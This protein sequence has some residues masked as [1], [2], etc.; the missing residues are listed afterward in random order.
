MR[1]HRYW[2]LVA[3]VLAAFGVCNSSAQTCNENLLDLQ[4]TLTTTSDSK[5]VLRAAA[6]GGSNFIPILHTLSK[7]S[8]S[9]STVPG[10]AQVA[11][12]RLG[13]QDAFNQLRTEIEKNPDKAIA[14]LTIIRT[15]ASL[16]ILM[17]YLIEHKNDPKRIEDMGDVANDPLWPAIQ[18]MI[19]MLEDPPYS[20]ASTL[21]SQ[22]DGW[23][24][25]WEQTKP[26]HITPI[27]QGLADPTSVCL[28]RLSEWG[29]ADAVY[30]LY[31][32]MGKNSIPV[33]KRLA[34]LG[35][36]AFPTSSVKTVR[37]AAQTLLAREGDQEQ[38]E[39]IVKELDTTNYLD[40][41]GKLQYIG[42]PASFEALM[43]SLTLQ[44]FLPNVARDTN[45]SYLDTESK[46]LREAV[47][48]ALSNLV[49]KPPLPPQAPPTS[50]NIEK[51]NAWWAANKGK[52]VFKNGPS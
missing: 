20:R 3:L 42:G 23:Q 35:D 25:W 41:V 7:P 10:A 38:F 18:G 39:K 50:E 2:V 13:D 43:H 22:L 45:R 34:H 21:P 5:F 28:A 1:R 4:K 51:W 6:V 48:T 27:S 33:L 19:N 11:L 12:A 29:Y 49:A 26:P 44:T 32:H 8:Q 9:P 16:S 14:K 24:R 40:A 46:R 31:L 30:E 37:G 52:N 17:Q 36:K 15:E 47:M